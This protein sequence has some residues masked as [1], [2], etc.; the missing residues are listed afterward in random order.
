MSS[1]ISGHTIIVAINSILVVNRHLAVRTI[2]EVTADSREIK[3]QSAA[4]LRSA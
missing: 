4:F 2:S 1:V 3:S